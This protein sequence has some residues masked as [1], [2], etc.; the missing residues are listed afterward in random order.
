MY[1]KVGL[2]T[3]SLQKRVM[4]FEKW[5]RRPMLRISWRDMVKNTKLLQQWKNHCKADNK[6]SSEIVRV[7]GHS[8]VRGHSRSLIL[9]GTNRKSV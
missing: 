2:W 4:A 3:K 7:G 5:C 1:V 6:L 8:V 9:I